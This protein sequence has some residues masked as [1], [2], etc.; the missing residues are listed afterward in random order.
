[1]GTDIDQ[2]LENLSQYVH[3]IYVIPQ[4]IQNGTYFLTLEKVVENSR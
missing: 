1:M 2:A 3:N 4:L